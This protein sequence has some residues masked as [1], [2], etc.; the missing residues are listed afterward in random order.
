MEIAGPGFVNFRL[1]DSWLH[2]VLRDVVEAG[3]VF[4]KVHR[5]NLVSTTVL[6]IDNQ[7]LVVP[8]SKIWG[9][10]ICNLTDQDPCPLCSDP[11]RADGT[12]CAVTAQE[13]LIRLWDG[14]EA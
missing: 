12:L 10:V 8:N 6:T 13:G 7:T 11:N 1:A 5:M 2:D 3:G 9:D 4:G 14:K